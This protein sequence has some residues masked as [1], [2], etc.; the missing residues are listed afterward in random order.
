MAAAF[1]SKKYQIQVFAFG[2][3]L[4]FDIFFSWKKKSFCIYLGALQF[5]GS[6]LAQDGMKGLGIYN[7]FRSIIPKQI[8]I[9][10]T[11]YV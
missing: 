6:Y 10:V 7:E 11:I 2:Y 9:I 1:S 4:I 5:F 3:W 8:C